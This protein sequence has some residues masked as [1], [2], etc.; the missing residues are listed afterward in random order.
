MFTVRFKTSSQNLRLFS[1]SCSLRNLPYPQ[2]A[3]RA[4][5]FQL[6]ECRRLDDV[7]FEQLNYREGNLMLEIQQVVFLYM[8]GKLRE[9]GRILRGWR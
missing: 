5:I 2:H 7:R 3:K 4:Y 9:R 6:D 8:H 1:S